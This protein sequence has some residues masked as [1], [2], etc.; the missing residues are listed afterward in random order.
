VTR[1]GKSPGVVDLDGWVA[2]GDQKPRESVH[3]GA[4]LLGSYSGAEPSLRERGPSD[5]SRLGIPATRTPRGGQTTR[6]ERQTNTALD[7]GV[8]SERH[9]NRKRGVRRIAIG[10]RKPEKSPKL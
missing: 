8:N 3:D 10:N 2:L 4:R 7:R 9:A 5:E 6:R 1:A